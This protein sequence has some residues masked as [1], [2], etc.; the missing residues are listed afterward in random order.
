M[1]TRAAA[2]TAALCALLLAC[3]AS[4]AA[5]ARM[6]YGFKPGASYKVTDKDHNVGK[7]VTE[8]NVMGQTQKIESPT[9]MAS[10]GTYVIKVAGRSQG[11]VKVTTT[12]GKR[13]GGERWAANKV[14]T[15]GMDMFTNS[16]AEAIIHP[17]DGVVKVTT[18]PAGDQTIEILYQARFA[19]MPELPEAPVSVGT[20]FSHD[21]VLKSGMYNVKTTDEYY[22]TEIRDGMVYLDV[23]TRSLSVFKM[24]QAPGMENIPKGMGMQMEDMK[25]AYKGEGTAVFDLKEGIFI[26]REGKMTYSD[27][28]STQGGSNMPGGM[29]FKGRTEGSVKYSYEMERE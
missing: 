17:L 14:D 15:S 10:Q 28:G 7:T 13:V 29:A 12:Y 9:D 22:V 11:G 26:E 18:F 20:E 27:L 2:L 5:S 8:I 16:R 6:R 19:W 24:N 21:F 25:L 1:N 3:P 4:E 23:E